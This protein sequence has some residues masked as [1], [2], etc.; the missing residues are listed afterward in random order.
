MRALAAATVAAAMPRASSAGSRVTPASS[1]PIPASLKR[2]ASASYLSA[3]SGR[4]PNRPPCEPVTT[5]VPTCSGPTAEAELSAH[6]DGLSGI[7][8]KAD[9]SAGGGSSASDRRRAAAR[10]AASRQASARAAAERRRRRVRVGDDAARD[11]VRAVADPRGVVPDRGGRNAEPGEIIEPA[12]PGMVAPDP[13]VVEDR[14]RDTQLCR[15]IGGIDAAMRAVDDDRA[16]RLGA[17]TGDA[18]GDQD[19]AGLDIIGGSATDWSAGIM[20]AVADGAQGLSRG[21]RCLAAM[22]MW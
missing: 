1:I 16:R 19:R 12:D 9:S 7:S 4:P 14:R 21:R 20:P 5:I 6:T 3:V 13:G 15:D 8:R 2:A 11:H 17:D 18:V 22:W 10:A